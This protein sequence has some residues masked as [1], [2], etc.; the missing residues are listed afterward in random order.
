LTDKTFLD[1]AM[2]K[3]ET[4][5]QEIKALSPD[6]LAAFRNWFSQ[7]DAET[8]DHQIEEDAK[9]GKLD[10]L[11]NAALKSFQSGGCSEI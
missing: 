2:S 4:I 10:A 9:S 6:E 5:E 11:A 1:I 7:F 8:W 3:I